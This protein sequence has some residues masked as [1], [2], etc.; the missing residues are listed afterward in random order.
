MDHEDFDVQSLA[1]YLHLTPEQV[2]KMASRDRLPGRRIGGDWK[3]SRADIHHWFE[4]KIGAADEKD[5][6]E[7]EQV[8]ESK[9]SPEGLQEIRISQLLNED[10]IAI[11][12]E[13][14]TRNSVVEKVCAIPFATGMLW[15][16]EKMAEA[17]RAREQLHPT[18]LENGVALL[19]PR[20]PLAGILAEPF[21]ALGITST[22]IPFGGPRGVLTDVFFLIAMIDEACHLRVLARL[23]RLIAQETFVE[24]I[25]SAGSPAAVIQLISDYE[26]NI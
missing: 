25:R 23:S 3:F 21:L 22:G 1:T 6:V 10:R 26:E 11:P 19:H 15:D 4:E 9:K 8:L 18:A 5:L 24:E 17:I 14:R 2:R 7:V 13:A 12:L 20:R 16:P